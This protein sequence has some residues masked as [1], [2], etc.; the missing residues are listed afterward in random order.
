MNGT[1]M[2]QASAQ[3]AA[4]P[5]DERFLTLDELQDSV[6]RRK[7]QSWTRQMAVQAI[8]VQDFGGGEEIGMNVENPATGE[9]KLLKPTNWAFSQLATYAGAPASYLRK[10]PAPLAVV[11]LQYGLDHFALRDDTLALAQSNGNEVLRAMTGV[12]YG[13]IWDSEVVGMVKRMNGDGRW[14]VP[15]ASYSHANPR[16]ATTLYASDRDVFIFLVDPEHPVEV[17]GET[18]FKGFFAWNSEVGKCVFGLTTF[19]YRYVC[20]NRIVWGATNV[21]ELRIKHTSGAPDRFI[22]EGVNYLRRYAEESTEKI[23]NTIENAKRFEVPLS[24]QGK[25]TEERWTNWLRARGFATNTAKA[26][27]ATAVI[28]EG[29]ARNLWDVVNGI[30]ANARGIQHTDSRVEMEKRA[31][32]LLEKY[33]VS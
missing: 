13:R 23:V 9:T 33:A 10:L 5:D 11:N 3:W 31:G 20:D 14:K 18:L 24:A 28:E 30:T 17:G 29:G 25:N 12:T 21:Q 19:L 27:V 16:R 15:A 32:D 4:R 7:Q 6:L 22:G 26:A 2:H 8:T 1:T